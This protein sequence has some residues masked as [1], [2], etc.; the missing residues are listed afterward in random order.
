MLTRENILNGS[1]REVYAQ[2]HGSTPLLTG[3]EVDASCMATLADAPPGDV[4]L[5]GYGSLIWNPTIHFEEKR[6]GTV[7]GYHRRF[8][9]WTQLGRGNPDCPG[10]LLGLEHGGACGGVV[11]RIAADKAEDECKVVWHREM[12]AG[13]YI[14]RWVDVETDDGTVHAITFVINHEHIRYACNL[15]DH[16]VVESVANAAGT[17]GNCAEYLINTAE[18]LE[19]LG[20]LDDHLRHLRSE[21]QRV[22][23]AK[24]D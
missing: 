12:I 3:E 15:P 1:I 9:L 19:E 23:A 21:V 5:F 14:P 22:C 24:K 6:I 18:H 10:L 7:T 4:W 8:C 17:L 13:S 20:I 2:G 11:F 16:E